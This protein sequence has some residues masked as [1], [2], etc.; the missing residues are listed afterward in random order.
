MAMKRTKIRK[1]RSQKRRLHPDT[2]QL[3]TR[4]L[5]G[6]CIIASVALMITGVWYGSRV[7]ALTIRTVAVSGGETIPHTTVEER[8]QSVL[9]GTYLRLVPRRFA[10]LYPHDAIIDALAAVPRIK[11]ITVERQNW[12]TLAVTFTEY[13]SDAL[14]CAEESCFFVDETGYAFAPA[15]PLR[16]GAFIRFSTDREPAVG[17]TVGSAADYASVMEFIALLEN[18]DVRVSHVLIDSVRDVYITLSGGG[19]LRLTLDVSPQT[20]FDNLMTV[21]EDPAFT[22][23]LPGTFQYIDLRFGNKVFVNRTA[24]VDEFATTTDESLV[25][26]TVEPDAPD[27][28]SA[29]PVEVAVTP[30]DQEPEEDGDI[31]SATVTD[32][33]LATTTPV[34]TE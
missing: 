11:D 4:I 9:E 1:K 24:V 34:D 33:D 23:V 16:G 7:E 2:V 32:E 29:S 22:D 8:T 28:P 6:V 27:E 31:V 3:L 19:E 12:Q 30:A 25:E 15:P 5:V 10:L 18:E 26:F 20:I 14:W 21:L 17:E 13:R